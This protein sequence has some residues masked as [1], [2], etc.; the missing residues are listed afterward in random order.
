MSRVL[1]IFV[2]FHVDPGEQKYL[3]NKLA[4]HI[5]HLSCHKPFIHR[6]SAG[7]VLFSGYLKV[8]TP[9]KGLKCHIMTTFHTLHRNQN[10]HTTSIVSPYIV[11]YSATHLNIMTTVH[12]LHKNQ[13]MHTTSKIYPLHSGLQWHTPTHH[14]NSPNTYSGLQ[15]HTPT[16]YDNSPHIAQKTKHT[17][18]INNLP[19]T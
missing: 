15:C 14:D 2:Y 6:P 16:H 17:H 19:P 12:T 3:C 5:S 9:H 8:H 18:N 7:V 4:A 10:M 11:V 1:V 13:S